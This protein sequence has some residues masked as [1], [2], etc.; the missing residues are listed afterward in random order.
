MIIKTH[1]LPVKRQ[2]EL[3]EIS[4]S[5]VYYLPVP[6]STKDLALPGVLQRSTSAH[7]A[8]RPNPGRGILHPTNFKERSLKE[9]R[10]T[11]WQRADDDPPPQGIHLRNA[12]ICL[13]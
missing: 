2:A 1:P 11:R 3:L 7:R 9:I 13:N 8:R 5:N 6:T 4:R 12:E 10:V